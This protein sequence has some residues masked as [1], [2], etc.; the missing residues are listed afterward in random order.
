MCIL[1]S[2]VVFFLYPK[3]LGT[4]ESLSTRDLQPH[5]LCVFDFERT[6]ACF[7]WKNVGDLLTNIFSYV[8]AGV[9]PFLI[10]NKSVCDTV[11]CQVITI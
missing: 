3:G 9:L 4:S 2:T 11:Y 6:K 10:P 5:G 1:N 7:Q 8:K